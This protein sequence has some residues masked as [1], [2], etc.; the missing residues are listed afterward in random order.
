MGMASEKERQ[1]ASRA[2]IDMLLKES[3]FSGSFEQW[4][5]QRRFITK[6]IDRD[7]TILDIGSANGLF[8]KSLEA[9]SDKKLDPYGVDIDAEKIRQAKELYADKPDHFIT[10]DK[11]APEGFP[12][13]FDIVYWNVWD[14]VDFTQPKGRQVLGKALEMKGEDG[15]LILGFYDH[16]GD[17]SRKKIDQ[18]KAF[19]FSVQEYPSPEG[20]PEKVVSIDR[21]SEEF[22]KK[23]KMDEEDRKADEKMKKEGFTPLNERVSY[24]I[25][26]GQLQLHLAESFEMKDRIEDMYEDA[27]RKI[28]DVVERDPS[29][30]SIGGLSWLNATKTYGSMKERLGFTV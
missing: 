24:S 17:D 27:L 23:F 21:A 22:L 14:N 19:G 5:E 4:E 10:M 25:K 28:V 1:L 15:R 16:D 2:D 13:T 8:L 9:W 11:S 12:K 6:A 7:G 3:H 30:T 18:L 26:E 20:R 29:I